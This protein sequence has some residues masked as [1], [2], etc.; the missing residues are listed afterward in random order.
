ML[1]LKPV[2]CL[3]VSIVDEDELTV[4]DSGHVRRKGTKKF[5]QCCPP[6]DARLIPDDHRSL[7]HL[8]YYSFELGELAVA[9]A[10]RIPA[11]CSG[12]VCKIEI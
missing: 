2:G 12:E 5:S 9:G 6:L 11:G 8:R 7:A 1:T 10:V 4:A 3:A